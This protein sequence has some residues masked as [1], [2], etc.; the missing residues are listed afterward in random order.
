MIFATVEE[1]L[2]ESTAYSEATQDSDFESKLKWQWY[3]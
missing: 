2:F 1:H 3:N